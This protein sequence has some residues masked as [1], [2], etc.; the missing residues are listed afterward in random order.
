MLCFGVVGRFTVVSTSFGG[1]QGMIAIVCDYWGLSTFRAVCRSKGV[2]GVGRGAYMYYL[3]VC[4]LYYV[5]LS[6]PRLLGVDLVVLF[7]CFGPFH[8]GISGY[9]H[10]PFGWPME[11]QRVHVVKGIAMPVPSRGVG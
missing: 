10:R 1:K 8:E 4:D 7:L 11:W 9:L 2:S 6:F 3:D 5:R